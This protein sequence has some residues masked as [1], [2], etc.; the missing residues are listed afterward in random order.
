MLDLIV[1]V[2]LPVLPEIPEPLYATSIPLYS[3]PKG[4]GSAS[5]TP[6]LPVDVM[7]S[8]STRF[9]DPVLNII[10]VGTESSESPTAPSMIPLIAALL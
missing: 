3:P 9:V 4:D 2:G 6:M 8:L 1:K 10:A 5:P 7:R